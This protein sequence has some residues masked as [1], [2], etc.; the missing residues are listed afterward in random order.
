MLEPVFQSV[1]TFES[2]IANFHSI[3][4]N[5]V[6]APSNACSSFWAQA[7]LLCFWPAS[8]PFCHDLLL[9]W[10]TSSFLCFIP[11]FNNIH[12]NVTEKNVILKCT[13]NEKWNKKGRKCQKINPLKTM[14]LRIWFL[15]YIC[16]W[17]TDISKWVLYLCRI[18]VSKM[19]V[20]SMSNTNCIL[21][22]AQ[23]SLIHVKHTGT[24]SDLKNP[25]TCMLD[26][27]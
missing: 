5:S 17:S 18:H 16:L 1:P 9:F 20:V 24:M 4:S 13:I 14:L 10:L 21:T 23:H 8:L 12:V 11:V 26:Q 22:L 19:I 3:L 25:K 27:Y 15:Y 6:N 2:V 7:C